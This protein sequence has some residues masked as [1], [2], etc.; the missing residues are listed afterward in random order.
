MQRGKVF[1][2]EKKHANAHHCQRL[3]NIYTFMNLLIH[4]FRIVSQRF[5]T[6]YLNVMF[7]I[8]IFKKITLVT[9]TL[10]ERTRLCC[11]LPGDMG[12]NTSRVI[13]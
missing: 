1:I 10:V 3:F 5:P 2:R 8:Y 6:I 9:R 13:V 12:R 7:N 11:I 4:L